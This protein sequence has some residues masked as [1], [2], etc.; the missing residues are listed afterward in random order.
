[1]QEVI[2]LETA[3]IEPAPKIGTHLRTDFIRGMGKRGDHFIMI[4]NIDKVFSTDE[5]VMVGN[6]GACAPIEEG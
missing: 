1:V 5:L 3:Q 6:A 4:L 2:E